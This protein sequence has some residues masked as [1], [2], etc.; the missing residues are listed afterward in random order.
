MPDSSSGI[1][2]RRDALRWLSLAPLASLGVHASRGTEM[3]ATSTTPDEALAY[4]GARELG[5]RIASREL[6]P[7]E[8]TRFMLDRIARIDPHY[9]SY[10]TVMSEQALGDAR[11]AEREIQA[12]RRRSPL[13]GVPVAIKD[14]CYTKGVR[15]M[16]GCGAFRDFVPTIDGT[17]V[18]KLRAA[19]AVILGKLNLTEGAMAGYNPAFDVPLNP[20]DRS[21]WPGLSSSG[22]GVA[23]AAGLCY[24]SIGTDTGGSIRFPSSANGVVGLKPTYGRVSRFGLL[25]FA[26]SLD[27]IGPMARRVA[28]VAVMLEAIAGRDVR[29]ATSLNDPVPSIST[30]LG[31]SIAGLRIGID[32]A[33]AFTKVDPGQVAS[34]EAAL[35]VFSGLGARI[36]DIK[37]PD[38]TGTGFA[39]LV[40][41]SSEAA[42]AHARTYPSQAEKYG[43]YIR[44]F[45]DT[46]RAWKPE[47]ITAAREVRK[48]FT[49][50]FTRLLDSVDA[51]VCPAGGS[52]AWTVT[53]ELQVGRM[54]PLGDAWAAALPRFDEFAGTLNLAGT[55]SV[56]LP[57]GFSTDGLPLGI[58][59]AGTKSSE[60]LLCRIAHAYEEATAWHT[61]HPRLV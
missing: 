36:V 25:P 21:R 35:D 9:K 61:R 20:W 49:A 15:T 17:V 28:D 11:L 12:G 43:P 27:H 37:M 59:I 31:K 40:L 50:E 10:A 51:M 55:P 30:Q 16:G 45:L 44:D 53:H 18:E 3:P 48:Q 54:K 26:E 32:R 58:Q 41:A 14:L 33:F 42:V 60:P 23:T 6:S 56:T 8:V 2:T 4:I 13:H 39:W 24:A 7:V 38:V 1:I 34:I 19:G 22:S 5:E 46:G 57:S 29:D 52:P 47:Q